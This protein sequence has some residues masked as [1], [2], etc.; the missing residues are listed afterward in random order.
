MGSS[1][2][3]DKFRG[4]LTAA[5]AAAAVGHAC[6]ELGHDCDEIPMSDGGEGL[7]DVL[8][9]PNRV[10]LVT[11]PL[12]DPVDAAWRL[13]R[14]T[15]V[16]EMARASGLAS[17]A[18]PDGNDPLLASTIGNRRADRPGAR[19]GARHR[20]IVGLGGSATTDGGLGAVEALRQ[21]PLA[22]HR[23]RWW[24]ATCAPASSTPPRC[25]RRRRER[26]P[27]RSRC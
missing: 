14:G 24:R 26:R 1:I 12:G 4:T 3:L 25:S 20:I 16:I 21:C 13:D 19:A 18:A 23:A 7:L 8:G 11:G 15:A 5:E 9:G 22:R 17:S 2:A 27:R 10:D 6:W